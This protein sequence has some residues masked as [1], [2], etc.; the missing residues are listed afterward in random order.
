MK[1]LISNFASGSATPIPTRSLVVSIFNTGA[2]ELSAKVF[3]EKES[4][5]D[6]GAAPKETTETTEED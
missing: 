3:L 2:L 6:D 1:P 4:T 5:T